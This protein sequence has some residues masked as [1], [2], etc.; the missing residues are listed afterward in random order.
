MFLNTQTNL[1]TK[2]QYTFF[3]VALYLDFDEQFTKKWVV[4]QIKQN[5]LCT[6]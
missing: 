4:E 1:S 6:Q 2:F 5:F 3:G